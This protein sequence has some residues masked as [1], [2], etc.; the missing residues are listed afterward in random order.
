MK[1]LLTQDDM[2]LEISNRY[3]SY[4]FYPILANFMINKAVRRECK[5]INVLAIC[6]K[7]NFSGTFKV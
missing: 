5:R 7:L 2:G 1:F 4:S 3:S 6:Q